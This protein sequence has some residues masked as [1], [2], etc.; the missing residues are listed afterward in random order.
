VQYLEAQIYGKKRFSPYLVQLLASSCLVMSDF[1]RIKDLEGRCATNKPALLDRYCLTFA[2]ASILSRDYEGA[3]RFLE[4]R[5]ARAPTKLR[6]RVALCRGFSEMLLYR[7]R[8]ASRTFTSIIDAKQSPL[9][10]A[11]A[12]WFIKDILSQ[13]V[14]EEALEE[15]A[16]KGKAFALTKL[17]HKENWDRAIKKLENEPFIAFVMKYLASAA[18]WIYS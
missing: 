2:A 13:T 6:P 17:P 7:H 8:E 9:P 3:I 16:E 12:A 15:T 18:G 5:D 4:G 11:L 1:Q 14:K 10:A